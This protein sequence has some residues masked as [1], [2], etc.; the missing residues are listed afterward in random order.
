[1]V[2]FL[3]SKE[4]NQF[5][6]ILIELT[7]KDTR[8]EELEWKDEDPFKFAFACGFLSHMAADQIIHRK[9]NDIAGPYYR[10]GEYRKIHRE[11]EVY[12][13]IA[14]FHELYPDEDFM[15][16]S[17]HLWVDLAPDSTH[18]APDWFRY[19]LQRAF[20][21][22]HGVYPEEKE[23]ENWVDGLLLILRGVKLLGPYK[24]AHEELKDEGLGSEK[25]RRYF[26]D[27]YMDLFFQAVELT[28][29]YW[30]MVFELYDPPGNVLQISE[31]MRDRFR[32]VVQN[33]DLS[34]PLQKDVLGDA[35]KAFYTGVPPKLSALVKTS[36]KPLNQKKILKI[37]PKD[38]GKFG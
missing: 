21:E 15:D 17:F 24:T 29:I 25:F 14:L 28:G 26:N 37:N 31:K 22:S 35:K 13:D 1:M 34:S 7:W 33:A 5:P 11:C 16:K 30:R 12:Q 2:L 6:L 4:P 38:I 23:I 20:V 18:N 32:R 10:K 9:V 8:W 19:F 36:K 27:F 3:H